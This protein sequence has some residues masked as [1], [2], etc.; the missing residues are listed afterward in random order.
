MLNRAPNFG[1]KVI[2]SVTMYQKTY[3]GSNLN[4]MQRKRVVGGNIEVGV[5]DQDIS[6]SKLPGICC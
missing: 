6:N 1:N 5:V 3:M 4:A 2:M